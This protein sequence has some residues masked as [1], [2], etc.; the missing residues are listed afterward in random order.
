MADPNPIGFGAA[1]FL[2]LA[3]AALVL[4]AILAWRLGNGTPAP[5]GVLVSVVAGAVL[6]VVIVRWED[7]AA[8]VEVRS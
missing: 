4:F 8:L 5:T 2:E 1:D 6:A 3:F 7:L